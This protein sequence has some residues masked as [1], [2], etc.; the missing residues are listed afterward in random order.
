ML[1]S[2]ASTGRACRPSE[3]I[4]RIKRIEGKASAEESCARHP[5]ASL[6]VL[7]GSLFLSLRGSARICRIE[8]LLA[9]VSTASALCPEADSS[10]ARRWPTICPWRVQRGQS[11]GEAQQVRAVVQ[12][13]PVTVH[14]RSGSDAKWP[15]LEPKAVPES[16]QAPA[17]CCSAVVV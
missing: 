9:P 8:R 4:A 13:A 11:V 12:L 3:F 17:D 15:V 5:S 6:L 1:P 10:T 2:V 16:V 14:Q 7:A